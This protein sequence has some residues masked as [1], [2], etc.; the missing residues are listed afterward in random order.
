M[1]DQKKEARK[2]ITGSKPVPGK[3]EGVGSI[4]ICVGGA[5]GA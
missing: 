2:G 3:K 1:T 5:G 4:Q